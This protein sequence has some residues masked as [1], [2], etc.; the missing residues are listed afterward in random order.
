MV[1]PGVLVAHLRR[2][3]HLD[4]AIAR[5]E[6]GSKNRARL[7]KRRALLHSRVA[8]TRALELHRVTNDLVRRVGAI[9]IEDLFV[10]GMA[11]RHGRL[12]RAISDAA[13]GELRHQL[14]YKAAECGTTLVVIDRF[15]PSSK[16]CSSCGSVKAGLRP[17][18]Q[19]ADPRSRKTRRAQV[20]TAAI[21]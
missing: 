7:I 14:T 10:T 16:T 2:L 6:R 17:E 3:R 9:G 4:R 11:R 5:G 18:T 1:N 21:A 20:P 15:Y 13:L 12:G 8:K 19:N